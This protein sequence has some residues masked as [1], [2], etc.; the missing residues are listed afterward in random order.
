MKNLYVLTLEPIEKRYT[1]Q[2]YSFW[3]KEFSK[4]FKVIYIDGPKFS[5]IIDKGKFLD[6]NKTNIWKAE[7]IKTVATLF[8]NGKIKTDDVFLFMDA[9]HPGVTAIK[10][11]IQLNKMNCKV[12]GYWHAGTYDPADFTAQSG[13]GEWAQYDEVAWFRA[14]DGSFVATQFH[15]KLIMES[16]KNYV[17]SKKIHVVGFPMDWLAAIE[18]EISIPSREEKENIIVF[19]H[20]IDKEK[21]PEVFD[22]LASEFPE[23]TFIKTMEVTKNK[24][25]YYKLLSRAKIVFSASSQ[26]TFG[27]G[28]V[29]ALMLDV[30]P[31]VPNTLSYKELYDGAFKYTSY[32]GA[33]QKIKCIMQRCKKY[34]KNKDVFKILDENKHKLIKQSLDAIPKMSKIMLGE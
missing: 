17:N 33:K 30:I 29:E 16:Y 19:P 20:R 7:Q 2:W 32:R 27:I 25:E 28:T 13:L 5:D 26:E 14:L 9:W 6:I 11:M 4:S 23:Y 3:K 10:Y 31:V 21:S 22:K 34:S 18:K 1:K 15:K 24:K 8:S 12:F